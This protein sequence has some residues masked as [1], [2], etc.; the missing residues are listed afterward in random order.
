MRSKI[1]LTIFAFVMLFACSAQ[2]V[3]FY[4]KE[5]FHQLPVG[6]DAQSWEHKIDLT[7]E[8]MYK[9]QNFVAREID[10]REGKLVVEHEELTSMYYYVK[11][12]LPKHKDLPM[13]G[14]I[15]VKLTVADNPVCP[16]P[17]SAPTDLSLSKVGATLKPIF[18][19]KTD[20]RYAAITLYDVTDQKTVWER[21]STT[22]GYK[23][24]DDG[25]LKTDHHYKWAVKVSNKY[26]AYSKEAMAGF[27][28]E[29]VDGVVVAIPE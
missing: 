22:Q 25:F 7:D 27:R 10:L 13:A 9:D 23:A 18:T 8:M 5:F 14:K 17:P 24:F 28:I 1:C 15:K 21:I 19:W 20:E 29:E 2:A 12:R 3:E 26:A 11:V 6:T 4:E 16:F